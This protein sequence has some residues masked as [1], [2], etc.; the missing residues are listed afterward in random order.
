MQFER[1]SPIP[2]LASFTTATDKAA[3]AALEL[4]ITHIKLPASDYRVHVQHFIKQKWQD[5]WDDQDRIKSTLHPTNILCHQR[6]DEVVLTRLRLGHS[7][8]TH[9]FLLKGENP[10]HCIGCYSRISV[11]HILLECVDFSNI[12]KKY[13][14]DTKHFIIPTGNWLI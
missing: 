6:R 4:A 5:H 1:R 9:S 13:F 7:Y 10:P 14:N 11:K 3:K 8:F 2:T 12:C